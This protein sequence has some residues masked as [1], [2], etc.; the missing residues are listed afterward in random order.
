MFILASGNVSFSNY[1]ILSDSSLVQCLLILPGIGCMLGGGYGKVMGAGE[2]LLGAHVDV[3]VLGVVQHAFQA[4]V[5]RYADR[6]WRKTC[7]LVSIIR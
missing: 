6:T 7:M 5:R 1:I 4:L 2:V 3:I